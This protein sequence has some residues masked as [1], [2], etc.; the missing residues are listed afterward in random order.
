LFPRHLPSILQL[1]LFDQAAAVGFSL[2]HVLKPVDQFTVTVFASRRTNWRSS[3][4]AP[5]TPSHVNSSPCRYLYLSLHRYFTSTNINYS[6]KTDPYCTLGSS[7][8]T[9][10]PFLFASCFYIP[11][12]ISQLP[13]W[14][15]SLA[16]TYTCASTPLTS[17][18]ANPTSREQTSDISRSIRNLVINPWKT[19]WGEL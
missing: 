2:V 12:P 16:S 19:L 17:L 9:P 6:N 10:G 4:H 13:P 5:P 1:V 7:S 15:P 18:I 14:L 8:T 11:R 3:N